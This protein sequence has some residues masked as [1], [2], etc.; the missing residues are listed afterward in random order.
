MVCYS[1][2]TKTLPINKIN[3]I[4]KLNF[5]NGFLKQFSE[6]MTTGLI[7]NPQVYNHDFIKLL[8]F[9]KLLI[10]I[11]LINLT[12]TKL[13]LSCSLIEHIKKLLKIN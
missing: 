10:I 6:S 13:N 9:V 2:K 1:C 7:N 5:F 4:P 8:K 11:T 3:K 12:F